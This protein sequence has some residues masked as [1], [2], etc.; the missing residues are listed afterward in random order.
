MNIASFYEKKIEDGYLEDSRK[1][2]F[3]KFLCELCSRDFEDII[4]LSFKDIA[5]LIDK[6]SYDD[7]LFELIN[8]LESPGVGS[9]FHL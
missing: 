7:E 1:E 4:H 3:A 2:V 9:R 5:N 8:T 6:N